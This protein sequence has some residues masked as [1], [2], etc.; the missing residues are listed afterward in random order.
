MATIVTQSL[1]TSEKVK[2]SW[3]E[4]VL[5]QMKQC[6]KRCFPSTEAFNFDIEL[7]KRNAHV[8]VILHG[9]EA[10]AKTPRLVAYLIFTRPKAGTTVSLHKIC[11]AKKY[12]RQGVAKQT[13]RSEIEILK[14]H[15]SKIQLMVHHDN[16]AAIA[17][18]QSLGF[19]KV[20]EIENYYSPGRRGIQMTLDLAQT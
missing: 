20:N 3:H 10:V 1:L 13:L 6:E 9:E 5:P 15:C 16:T 2:C 19:E 7:K 18:Y 14:R 12:R 4:V 11:V 17:L 8:I